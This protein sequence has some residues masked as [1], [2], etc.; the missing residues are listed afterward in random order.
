MSDA[1][2]K[3]GHVQDLKVYVRTLLLLFTLTALTVFAAQ[4]D[5]GILNNLVAVLIAMIK[6]SLVILFFM[7][8]K[9]EGKLTW[10]FIYYP[11]LLLIVLLGALFL[12]YGTRDR[13]DFAVQAKIATPHDPHGEEGDPSST[14]DGAAHGATSAS[15]EEDSAPASAAH[16]A[17][18]A[19][20]QGSGMLEEEQIQ[21]DEVPG[22]AEADA[23]A[24]A[25]D[26]NGAAAT[27]GW[28]DLPGDAAK[29][30]EKARVI[31]IAC[32]VVDELGQP[33]PGS[34]P[35]TESANKP[36]ITPDYLRRWFKDPARLKPGT[37]MPNFGLSEEEIENLIAFLQTYRQ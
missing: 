29:G 7:H 33:F 2:R 4:F 32:H 11:V 3:M 17:G 27:A 18:Q 30:R 36:E 1:S 31:C 6:A 23:A 9:Y 19:D 12:D 14:K 28:G 26:V 22:A 10:A 21:A 13:A 37:L 20:Q 5:V 25:P 34:P 8:G 24:S 16:E 35:F 15:H